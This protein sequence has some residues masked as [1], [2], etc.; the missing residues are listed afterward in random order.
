MAVTALA[1]TPVL[2]Q[3]QLP[4]VSDEDCEEAA[5]DEAAAVPSQ[6]NSGCLDWSVALI[7]LLLRDRSGAAA[8]RQRAR[9]LVARLRWVERLPPAGLLRLDPTSAPVQAGPAAS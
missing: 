2:Q 4:L 8:H 5:S 9:R 7:H 6:V 3:A 1:A